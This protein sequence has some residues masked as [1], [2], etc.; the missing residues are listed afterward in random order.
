[1]SEIIKP[2]PSTVA[3]QER[4]LKHAFSPRG[5]EVTEFC[6][7]FGGNSDKLCSL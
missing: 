4:T 2:P 6:N 3:A 5:R 7:R 1:V